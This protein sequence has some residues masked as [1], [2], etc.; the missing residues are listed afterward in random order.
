MNLGLRDLS[1][2]QRNRNGIRSL[3]TDD[4]RPGSFG[5][6]NGSNLLAGY[7]RG[8]IR[9]SLR[10]LRSGVEL[11]SGAEM[12][13]LEDGVCHAEKNGVCCDGDAGGIRAFAAGAA[14][15]AAK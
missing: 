13:C 5:P 10:M 6:A 12:K 7:V 4:A 3:E 9:G 8:T 11:Y 14:K 15:A 1:G 2:G